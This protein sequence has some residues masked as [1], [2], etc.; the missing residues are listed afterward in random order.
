[1]PNVKI[2]QLPEVVAT[3]GSEKFLVVQGGTSKQINL[4]KLFYGI[5]SDQDFFFDVRNNND[6]I[7]KNNTTSLLTIKS[8]TS[9]NIGVFNDNPLSRLHVGGDFRIGNS[10][11]ISSM[12]TTRA[13]TPAIYIAPY[14]LVKNSTTVSLDT[15]T[16]LISVDSAVNYTFGDGV[17]GQSKTFVLYDKTGTGSASIIPTNR[18]GFSSVKL[19]IL[20]SSV[21][22]KFL[23]GKWVVISSS[24]ASII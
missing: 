13:T 6:F 20:G 17:N 11:T 2:S 7:V 3:T 22:M 16:T 1:M 9:N 14:E 24:Q 4:N 18:I 8:G 21:T 23:A 5:I 15:D 10:P 12:T 19:D